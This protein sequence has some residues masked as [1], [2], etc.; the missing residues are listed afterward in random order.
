MQRDPG[1]RRA[2][3][4]DLDACSR[5]INERYGNVPFFLP[6][7]PERLALRLERAGFADKELVWP[8]V[9]GWGDLYVCEKNGRVVACAGFC[10]AGANVREVWVHKRTHRRAVVET[11]AVL[12]AGYA[13]GADDQFIQ[14]VHHCMRL[15]S[16]SGRNRL[17]IWLDREPKLVEAL[18]DRYGVVAETRS[19][20][21]SLEDGL[22]PASLEQPFVEL[23]Y[24]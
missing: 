4:R 10:D 5:L 16:N 23:A 12:D 21:C 19:L 13:N 20:Q 8:R 22:P 15:T 9:Y 1:I 24:W 18:S 17:A 3:P 11:A 14:L 2:E 6:T 7:T